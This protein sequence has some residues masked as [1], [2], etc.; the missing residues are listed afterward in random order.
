MYPVSAFTP[1]IATVTLPG[2]L[3][4][5]LHAIAAAGFRFV[6][7]FEDDVLPYTNR[8]VN[9]RRLCDGL[10]LKIVML[11]PFREL[12]GGAEKGR[13]EDALKR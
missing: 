9:V 5:K 4:D 6:E 1:S 8:L 13:E 10:G 7:L 2:E 3:E 12:E 11:Q